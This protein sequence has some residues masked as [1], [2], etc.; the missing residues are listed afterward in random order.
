V[1]GCKKPEFHV[2][3]KSGGTFQKKT[4]LKN[5]IPKLVYKEKK[6]P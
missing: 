4:N 3:F 5:G 2:D 1:F 6:S